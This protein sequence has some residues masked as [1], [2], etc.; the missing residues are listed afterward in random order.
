MAVVFSSDLSDGS[1]SSIISM[2]ESEA[3][4]AQSLIDAINSFIEGTRNS[5]TGKAYDMARQKM[6]MYTQDLKVRKQ[7]AMDLAKAISQGASSLLEYME[8]FFKLDDSEI[9]ELENEI[10][11]LDSSI[12][13]ARGT[14]KKIMDNS[15]EDDQKFISYYR[16]QINFWE[17]T[18]KDLERKLEKLV[19]LASADRAAFTRVEA[20]SNQVEQYGASVD[21]ISISS[22]V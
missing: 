12:Y 21:G 9:I 15:E 16:S 10:R 6:S 5:L 1:I 22:I 13:S 4:D 20:V 7:I 11:K 3:D 19:N 17:N 18:K 2:L 14:I 8:E